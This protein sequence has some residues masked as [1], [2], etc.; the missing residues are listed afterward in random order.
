MEEVFVYD[1]K[2]KRDG[3][4]SQEFDDIIIHYCRHK[5]NRDQ[6][7]KTWNVAIKLNKVEATRLVKVISAIYE[8]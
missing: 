3:Y 1:A 8:L 6:K 5:G 2:N 4:I 7:Y